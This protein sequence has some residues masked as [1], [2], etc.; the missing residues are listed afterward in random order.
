M[1]NVQKYVPV[2]KRATIYVYAY[3]MNSKI[4]LPR[5]TSMD[6][7]VAAEEVFWILQGCV[8][9]RNGPSSTAVNTHGSHLIIS[10]YSFKTK[11]SIWKVVNKCSK[12][13][14]QI[15]SFIVSRYRSNIKLS[16][17][18]NMNK[19]LVRYQ[20][21]P[22]SQKRGTFLPQTTSFLWRVKSLIYGSYPNW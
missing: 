1:A 8:T 20:P 16:F 12:I 4:K 21:R 14:Y 2:K 7:F 15:Y 13:M 3:V 10:E 19:P 17:Y 11:E 22:H 9:S 18:L 6:R 5:R